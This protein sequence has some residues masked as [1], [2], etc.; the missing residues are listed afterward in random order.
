MIS[1][2]QWSSEECTGIYVECWSSKI[3]QVR[4][5]LP[6]QGFC[7]NFIIFQKF[8]KFYTK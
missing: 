6:H 7:N 3:G 2:K 4:V 5:G 1:N 8:H